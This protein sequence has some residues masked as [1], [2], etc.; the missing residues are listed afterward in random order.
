[1]ILLA[2]TILEVL[3]QDFSDLPDS[4]EL[5][6]FLLRLLAAIVLG[7]LLGYQREREGKAAGI[8]T[9]MLVTLGAA[10]FVLV[11]QMAAMNDAALSRII[12]GVLTG[13]GFLGGGAILKLSEE[14]TVHGL[15]TAANLWVATAIGI[16][17]GLGRMMS[18]LLTTAAAFVILS[19][20]HRV[21]QSLL[22]KDTKSHL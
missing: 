22:K 5:F 20:F 1:M 7:G 3:K 8:R 17:V 18:A 15:T 10:L 2:T 9:H 12:Q 16:T 19:V 6:R 14:K 13:I 11:P 21:E 4:G